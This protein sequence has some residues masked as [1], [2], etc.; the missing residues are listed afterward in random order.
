MF[1]KSALSVEETMRWARGLSRFSSM[2]K[3][4]ELDTTLLR[5]QTLS[6]GRLMAGDILAS[7]LRCVSR[8]AYVG[9]APTA[10]IR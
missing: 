4:T 5:R 10:A 7:I 6:H 8:I 3:R 2:V 9:F 1:K